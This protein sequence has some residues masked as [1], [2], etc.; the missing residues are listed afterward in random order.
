MTPE[1]ALIFVLLGVTL[2]VI[3]QLIRVVVGIKKT[4]DEAARQNR[5]FYKLFK[6]DQLF[7]S[8]GITVAI[9]QLLEDWELHN[10][11]AKILLEK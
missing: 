5:D 7:L 6:K 2:G 8:I 10:T 3:G 11:K 4:Y 9:G 1:E